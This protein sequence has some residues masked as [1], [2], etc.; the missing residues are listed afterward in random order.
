MRAT[1]E[2]SWVTA[3]RK[4]FDEFPAGAKAVAWPALTI[5]AEGGMPV[6]V[7]PL[8]GFEPGIVEVAV[9]HGGN[10]Y[11]VII[12]LRLGNDMWVLH[13]FQKKSHQGIRTPIH[14]LDV[15][16]RRIRR[17]REL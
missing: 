10:A 16:R 17:I 14:E 1:R 4:A 13:A 6:I 11:R 7:K 9:R 3:A 5:L 15:A 12:G 2:I 8:H